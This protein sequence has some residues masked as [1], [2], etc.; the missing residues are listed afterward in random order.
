MGGSLLSMGAG[1]S[2]SVGRGWSWVG[3]GGSSCT[4][5]RCWLST[6]HVIWWW[7]RLVGATIIA[8]VA[9]VVVV[10]VVSLGSCV[11]VVVV[12]VVRAVTVL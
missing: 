5:D 7:C 1:S 10:V 11:V 2:S 3:R 4:T 12:V 8:V 6:W 9:V